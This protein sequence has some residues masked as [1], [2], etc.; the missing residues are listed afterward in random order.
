MIDQDVYAATKDVSATKP[1]V[2]DDE[3]VTMTMAQILIKMKA[4]KAKL[5]D[6]QIAK[7]LHDE[8]V[9]KVA[10][11]DKQEKDDVERAQVLQSSMMTKRKTLTGMLLL[12]K[13]KKNILIISGSIKVKYHIIDWEIHFEG[14]RAYWN[15]IRVVGI[16]KAYQSFKDK[17]KGFDREDPV[18][19]WSLVKEKFSSIVPNVDKEKALWVKLKR[20]F[21]PDA[22]DVLWK[23]QRE[24]LS[25]VKWSHDSNAECKV[26]S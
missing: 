21:E 7:S 6:E 9:V 18:A 2:F 16:T 3:E 8:E 19:L 20:L 17:L 14:S 23:L 10:A 5:I 25:L 24:R 13:Y 15:I 22:N 11:R 12:S 1:T 26:I 4:E